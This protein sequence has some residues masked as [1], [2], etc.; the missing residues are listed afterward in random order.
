MS[1]I[2]TSSDAPVDPLAD[3]PPS[4]DSTTTPAGPTCA[5]AE[6]GAAAA[7][8]IELARRLLD[9]ST[10]LAERSERRRARR[11][12]RLLDDAD[13]RELVV[14]LTDEV[15]R[16]GHPATAARRFAAIVGEHPPASLGSLDRGLLRAGAL[17]VPRLPRIVMP[18]V[19]RRIRSETAGIVIPADDPALARHLDRRRAD[20]VA[21]NVNPLGEAILSDAEADARTRQ[22]LEQ[23]ER[24]DVDHVSI[25][26]SAIVAHLDALATDDGV[27]RIV[28]R[29]RV[30]FRA[31]T[32]AGTFVNLDMEEYRD[33]E[34][35]T[36]AFMR[37]LDEPE[38]RRIDAGIVAQAY[39]PDAHEA[40]E[41]LGVW[42]TRRRTC[43]GGRIRVRLVKGANLAMERIEAELHGW[44]P[45][46][47]PTK[48]EV[49]A[50]YKMLLDSLLRPEWADAVLVG[51]ASHNLFDLAWA[52]LVAVRAG[53][54]DRMRIE[55]LEGMAPAQARAAHDLLGGEIRMYAPVVTDDDFVASLAYLS[56]RL[57]ENTQPDNFLRSLFRLAEDRAEFERQAERFRRSVLDRTTVSRTRRRSRRA[58]D[59][60]DG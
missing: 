50:S 2:D 15:L 38:F 23:I 45:A 16:I 1:S 10:E 52:H 28:E 33:L 20:G 18:L 58:I 13:G 46:P 35:T 31:A 49:D 47:Y 30:L 39:L 42:A 34:L 3:R 29:L 27:E 17:A 48:A 26:V 43:G 24:A 37:L 41:R 8:A 9:R 60:D 7:R 14:R 19:V 56:R 12:G 22:V 59:H 36:A 44:V 25:K 51:V 57:D 55:M 4:A 40:V 5:N 54:R 21:L 53:Q 32:A 11:L 6:S